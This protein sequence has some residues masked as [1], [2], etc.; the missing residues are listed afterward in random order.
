MSISRRDVASL[1][2][3]LLAAQAAH[4]QDKKPMA[5]KAFRYQDLE[6]KGTGKPSHSRQYI[7]GTTHT[8]YHID[9]HETELSAGE[10]PHASH[11]HTHEEMVMVRDGE[12]EVS[13]SGKTTRIGPGGAAYVASNEEHGW[14]NVGTTTARYFVIAF[15]RD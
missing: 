7:D 6:V 1:L 2:P 3:A 8:G 11:H 5:S 4:G 14:R 12:L 10:M 13:I 9:M 15:G